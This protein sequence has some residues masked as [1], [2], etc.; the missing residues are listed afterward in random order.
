MTMTKVYVSVLICDI[1]I[2]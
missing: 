2:S 1:D